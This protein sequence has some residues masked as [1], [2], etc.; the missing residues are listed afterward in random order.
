MTDA[1]N[2]KQKATVLGELPMDELI[3]YGRELG[4]DLT[5][6]MGRGEVLR[7]LR[8]RQELLLLMDR[9]AMLDIVVWAR[10]PVRKSA[11]KE[12]LA[13]E[14]AAVKRVRFDGLSDRGVVALAQLRGLPASDHEPRS[15]VEARLKAAEPFWDMVERK[16]R[17][18]VGSLVSRLLNGGGHEEEEYRF[19][20]EEGRYPSLKEE[21]ADE[22]LVGGIARKIRGAADD[23]LR[24]K[25]DEIEMRIDRK[26]DEIDRRLEEWRDREVA[27]RL[28]IIK[29]TLV[30]SVIVALISLGYKYVTQ[31]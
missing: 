8:E 15:E 27:N 4:L 13:K 19:L 1:Q 29:I 16:R 23:Y 7:R 9:D 3:H 17:R 18:V 30:A 25:M 12:E 11:S 24:Q 20:P 22:G 28:K 21:I 5:P 31:S 2:D 10:R 6:R 26:L 14:I